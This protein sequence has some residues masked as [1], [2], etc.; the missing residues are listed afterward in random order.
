MGT[1][2]TQNNFY[3]TDDEALDSRQGPFASVAEALDFINHRY[4]G[5]TVYI[6]NGVGSVAEYW[7]RDGID[8]SD[9]ILK[10]GAGGSG[11][12]YVGATQN[13]DLGEYQLKAGQIEFDQTPTGTSGVAVL[14]WNDTDGTLDL[15]LKGGAVTLQVG[16][17]QVVRVVN[18]T[19]ANLLEANYQAVRITG[20][21]GQRLQVA[22]AQANNDANSADTLG[23]VTETINN[24]QEG[25]VTI[26]GLVNNINTTGTLQAETWADGDVLYLSPTVAGR[27][28]NIKPVAPDHLVVV[29][30]V[31]YSHQNHG[32]IFV[33]VDNGYE[34]EELHNI[35]TTNYTTLID[36]DSLL[37]YDNNNSLWKRLTWANLKS[38]LK[39]YFDTLYQV[40]ITGAAST[41]TTSNLTPSRVVVTDSSG[42]IT[43]NAV[44]TTT[45][46]YL[47]ATSSIQTQINALPKVVYTNYTPESTTSNSSTNALTT[48][49][50][51][52]SDANWPLG[53]VLRLSGLMERTAG[54][55][56]ISMGIAVNGSTLRYF[57]AAGQNMQWEWQIMKEAANTLRIGMGPS[58]TGNGSYQVHNVATVTATA[59]GG[60]YVFTFYMWAGTAGGTAT[61]RWMKGIMIP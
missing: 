9:L 23:L 56:N 38:T 49:T 28:T 31:A 57:T 53:G 45:L 5:L 25:F 1:R 17:E 33:K 58:N 21:Q 16:Q 55:G 18:G 54:A 3:I 2:Y 22:L 6:D 26:S 44:T 47:D 11:V 59:S 8:D 15:G 7:F 29:G 42:K 52:I 13:V 39:T 19:G 24:N 50:L 34:L 36:S 61:M 48:F 46:G 20:A 40:T 43:T 37:T 12:P 30:Y 14:R 32:K 51:T 10:A 4:Q 60:N 41:I 35:T 27:I